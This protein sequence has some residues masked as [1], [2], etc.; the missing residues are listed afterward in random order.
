MTPKVQLT[1]KQKPMAIPAAVLVPAITSTV[2]GGAGIASQGSMNRKTRAFAREQANQQR[3]WSLDDWDR[4]NQYN[5]P[6]AQMQRLRDAGLNAN[7]VYGSD[8]ANTS[9]PVRSS[10][11]A[12]WNPKAPDFTPVAEGIRNSS[13]DYY[14]IK[15]TEAQTDNLRAQN[16][17]LIQEAALKAATTAATTASTAKSQF[18]LSQSQRLADIS[19][20]TAA[21]ELRKVRTGTDIAL[22]GNERQAATTAQSLQKGVQEIL[23]LRSQNAK[24]ADERKQIQTATRDIEK[25]IELKQLD[26][27]LKRLGIQPGDSIWARILGRI[28]SGV[29]DVDVKKEL[30]LKDNPNKFIPYNEISKDTMFYRKK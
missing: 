19:A 9:Q 2:L 18:D 6:S 12:D 22:Q 24:T 13:L 28:I 23:N 25:N 16:S 17:V 10:P 27:N 4:N 8:A 26:I 3:Q 15:S 14:N 29:L 20:E 30:G 21:E 5:H 1:K 11:A 7:L